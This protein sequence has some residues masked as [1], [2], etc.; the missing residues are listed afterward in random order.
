MDAFLAGGA[1]Y[2]GAVLNAAFYGLHAGI[3]L[4]F[5]GVHRHRGTKAFSGFT[6]LA[7]TLLFVL[8][9]GVLTN[10]SNRKV[11]QRFDNA[12]TTAFAVTDFLAQSLLI[13]RCWIVWNKRYAI[14]VLPA[15]LAT[16]SFWCAL[17]DLLIF[18][19]QSLQHLNISAVENIPLAAYAISMANNT[20]VTLLLVM[21]IWLLSRD[22]AK[23]SSI[24]SDKVFTIIVAM[25]LESG[26]TIFFAQLLWVVLFA[27]GSGG[28]TVVVGA[29]TQTYAFTP[30]IILIRVAIGASYDAESRMITPIAFKSSRR[31]LE[32]SGEGIS[33]VASEVLGLDSESGRGLSAPEE[34]EVE[35]GD[36]SESV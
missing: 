28:Y 33:S 22:F 20:I 8:G 4:F 11:A 36:I 7:S 31:G 21:R 29:I 17:S 34:K 2:L 23:L 19:T 10:Q 3:Y 5:L 18:D 25:L 30:T 24:P 26:I 1:D 32:S 27:K 13:F 35:R 14:V 16:A 15:I 9:T 12:Y 6:N